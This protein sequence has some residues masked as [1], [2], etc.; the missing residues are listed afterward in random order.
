MKKFYITTSIA[1]T[2]AAPKVPEPGGLPRLEKSISEL[3]QL[4][5]QETSLQA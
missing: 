3:E 4:H 1:Y 2:N 5:E